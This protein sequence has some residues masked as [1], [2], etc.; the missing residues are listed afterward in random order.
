MTASLRGEW[1]PD[2]RCIGCSEGGP[3]AAV[4]LGEVCLCICCVYD[5]L[6]PAL[7]DA[8]ERGVDPLRP[9]D[10]EGEDR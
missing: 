10:N 3:G 5:A 2:F 1:L 9:F 8:R 6:G 4:V 7:K